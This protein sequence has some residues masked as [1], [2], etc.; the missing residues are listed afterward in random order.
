MDGIVRVFGVVALSTAQLAAV[1]PV[2]AFAAEDP[3]AFVDVGRGRQRR[4]QR[5]E[6]ART[7]VELAAERGQGHHRIGRI[8]RAEIL[9]FRTPGVA[10]DAAGLIHSRFE[11]PGVELALVHH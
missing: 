8:G 5:F 4:A 9:P 1:D 7:R 6:A 2:S 10:E 3:P 11:G